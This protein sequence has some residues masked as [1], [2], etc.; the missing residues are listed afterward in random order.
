MYVHK[1]H[2]YHHIVNYS[3]AGKVKTVFDVVVNNGITVNF[4][5]Q[6]FDYIAMSSPG[7]KVER[8]R[9]YKKQ[10]VR[11]ILHVSFPHALSNTLQEWDAEEMSNTSRGYY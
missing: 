9:E 1:H 3:P 11:R 8:G 5:H 6:I 2:E 10:S 7:G 4:S